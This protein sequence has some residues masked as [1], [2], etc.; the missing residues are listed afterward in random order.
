L[1]LLAGASA[2][3]AVLS[4]GVGASDA[5]PATKGDTLT[6]SM[7]AG[8]TGQSAWDV[9]I[10]NFERVYPNIKINVTYGVAAQ[11]YQIETTELAAGNAPD[12]L[13]TF[14]GCG[15][16]VSVC[17]LA[18]SGY[19]APMLK[20]PWVKWSLP[21]V[22][23]ADKYGQGLFAFTLVVSPFGIWT[24]DDLFRKLGLKIPQTFAQL[25]DVCQKA[26]AAGTVALLFPGAAPA[27][28]A[29][30]IADLT[31]ATVYGKDK[32]W[33]TELRAGT[34][35]FDGSQ[36]WHQALQ[37]L[38]DMNNTGCFQP[39]ATGTTDPSV[40]A[41]FAQG[42]GLMYGGTT[43][44]KG[45]IDA[46]NPQFKFSHHPFPGGTDPNQTR[47][48]LNFGASVGV[49]A[50]SSAQAQAAA[51]TFVEF[52][53]R[54]K[55]NALFAQIQGGLT[56]YEFLKGR[57]PG[58]MSD[59]SSVLEQHKYVI[60]PIG[61]WWNANVVLALQQNQVGVITGQ[62]SIDDVLNAMDA[63]WKQGPT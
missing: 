8:L 56:Q 14:P 43:G 33:G 40:L 23:S 50:H 49:N 61:F 20:A 21:L 9:L 30:L 44:A 5:R 58:Y 26:K 63:A 34:V 13:Y 36:G 24:N 32:H 3:V 38:I 19:L 60:N 59:D 1:R 22:T 48:F 51:Q 35:T 4:L 54:P 62:R 41:Q 31:V 15:T 11:I 57:F 18:K 2:V 47:T 10:A 53:A 45:T 16:P 6:I 39:G 27:A 42:Q 7:L 29:N 28:V 12:L 17:T 52:I 37:H 46:G 25:L 55:Q